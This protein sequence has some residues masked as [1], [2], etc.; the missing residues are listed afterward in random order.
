MDITGDFAVATFR[1]NPPV[2]FGGPL[3]VPVATQGPW[4][5]IW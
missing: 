2:G 3:V 5:R 1:M 4:A